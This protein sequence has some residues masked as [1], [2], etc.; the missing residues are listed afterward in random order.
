[1]EGRKGKLLSNA[2][3]N[4]DL[5]EGEAHQKLA[6]AISDEILHDD[7]CTIIGIDGG[8]GS[9]KSN[10]VGMIEK[11]LSSNDYNGKYHFFTYDAWG[12]QSDLQRRTILEELTTDLVAGHTPIL[13]ENSW[14][15]SLENLLAKKKHTSTKTVPAIGLGA[16]VSVFLILLTPFVTHLA[17]L[18]SC[19]WLRFVILI[20]P[21]ALAYGF[22]GY[23]HYWKMT[24]K[25]HQNFTLEQYLSEFFL[26]YKDKIQEETK[27]ETISEKEPSSRQF[28][29]WVHEI[30]DGL[31]KHNNVVL[32]LVIDNMDR[33]PKQKVQELWSAIHS[34]FSEEKYTNIRIVVPFDRAHIRN[35]FQ[36]E[37][38]AS[39]NVENTSVAVYGDDFINKTFYIVYSVPPPILSGWKH[40]FNDRWKEAFGEEISVD[41]QVLQ[42]YDFLTR[43]QSP[44]KIIAFINQFVTLRNLCDE[45]IKDKYI[46]LY[47]FGRSRI[48]EN[49]LKEILQPS[50]LDGLKFLFSDDQIMPKCISS[51]YY[52]LPL[53]TAMDVVFTEQVTSELNDNKVNILAQLKGSSNYWDILYHSITNVSNVENAALA[54]EKQFND[55]VS[56][57]VTHIWDTLY[58]MVLNGSICDTQYKEYH[59]VL[60]K[61]I[62]E[63]QSYYEQLVTGYHSNIN[64]SFDLDNYINGIDKLHEII[65]E[66]ERCTAR[67]KSNV[68]PVIYLQLVE[69]RQE[70]FTEYGLVVE[71]DEFDDYLDSLSVDKLANE[72]LYPFT[73]NVVKTPKYIDKI[74]QHF[75]NNKS[76]IQVETKLLARLKEIYHEER[77]MNLSDILDDNDIYNLLN[78]LSENDELYPDALS[79][80]ISR[81][82]YGNG[83][84]RSYLKNSVETLSEE[85][86]LK[87]ANCIQYYICYGD[88]MLQL[89]KF[90]SMP[91]VVD[92]VR[93]LVTSSFGESIMDIKESLFHYD[94]ISSC[95]DL[96]PRV[97]LQDWDRWS[98]YIDSVTVKDVPLLSISLISAMKESCN[99]EISKHCLNL[100][101]IYLESTSQEDWKRILATDDFNMKLLEVY[102][103]SLLPFFVDAF[104]ESLRDY[105]LDNSTI[106]IPKNVTKRSIKILSDMGYNN[107]IIFKDIRDVLIGNSCITENKLKY[108]GE[109]LFEYGQIEHNRQIFSKIIKSEYLGDA[110]IVKMLVDYKETVRKILANDDN[111]SDFKNKMKALADSTYKDD[112]D[113]IS[114]CEYLKILSKKK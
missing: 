34:C 113:F 19:G 87:V 41:N 100:V 108:F 114:L 11:E 9:G 32:I 111:P 104:K 12:H 78:K 93:K 51:L 38:I 37:N 88:L 59:Y 109:F 3:C 89:E 79:M 27:F 13:N 24:D 45:R 107:S 25:Y 42:I 17:S 66:N 83:N 4:T 90:S 105:A 72:S 77:P 31:R 35:A 55:E 76:N 96:E 23:R 21:Y 110:T 20:V 39:L 30:D 85:G 52:Q 86:I 46:A 69:K 62:S 47:I 40:Y 18:T 65:S 2:P 95:L 71:E 98:D 64:D 58:S 43:E 44:R 97:I 6:K 102:H 50:Y 5:F 112:E 8:W 67:F 22:I 70:N 81:Y 74:R 15:D 16:I 103:P 94:T 80:A 7:K 101:S 57:E 54:L 1:M 48:S 82:Q 68:S 91:Y 14:K 26:I 75:R 84:I 61:H 33:L 63:R 99:L 60:L 92:V 36:S 56:K 10:L 28:K 53:E 29:S 49:P 73:R 106:P